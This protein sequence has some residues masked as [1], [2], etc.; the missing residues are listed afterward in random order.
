[1]QAIDP[2]S[3]AYSA[4]AARISPRPTLCLHCSTGSSSQWRSLAQHLGEEHRIM[5]PD[6]LGYGDNAP[7]PRKRGLRLEMESRRLRHLLDAAPGPVDVVAHSFGGAVAINLAL[8]HPHKVRSLSLYEPVLFGLLRNDAGAGPA[9]REVFTTSAAIDGALANG[10]TDDASRRFI[11]FWSGAGRWQNLPEAH[12]QTIRSRIEKVRADFAALLADQTTLTMLRRLDM[13]VLV[14]SGGQ[15]PRA[16]RHIAGLLASA[17][18]RS[19]HQRFAQA[20]H[21]GPLTHAGQI[22]PCIGAFIQRL[23][24]VPGGRPAPSLFAARAA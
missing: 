22:N 6:L 13:P 24:R 14:M 11:D 20:G 7:W 12:R 21:M 8:A 23:P 3:R 9:L 19:T 15:S 1:M 18:P 5:A 16:A 4:D 10:R 17:L 2:A